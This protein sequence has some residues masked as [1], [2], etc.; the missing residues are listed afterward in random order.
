MLTIHRALLLLATLAF[1]LLLPATLPAQVGSTTDILTGRIT[2]PDSQP[3]AGAHVEAMSTE[4]GITRTTSTDARGRYTIVFPDGGGQYQ[5]TVRYLGMA[6]A[7]LTVQRQADEDRLITNVS[8]SNTVATLAP[9]TVRGRRQPPRQGRE[10]GGTGQSLPPGLVNRLPIDPGDLNALATLA[11]GVVGVAAT[12]STEA[13]FSVAGQPT[14]QNQITL[15]GLSFGSG[16]VPS[17]AIRSTRVITSTYDVARGQFTGGEVAATTRSGTNV[18]Q[19]AGTYSLRSRSLEL[20]ALPN[21]A[22]TQGFTQ[23]QFGAGAGGP[24]QKNKLFLFGA[25]QVNLRSDDVLSLLSASPATF[26]QLGANSDSVQRFLDIARGYGIPS[27]VAGAPMNR[28]TDNATALVRLD[29]NIGELHTLTLRGD[30]RGQSQ[31]GGRVSPLALPSTGGDLRSTGGG[32]M[33]ALT[34]RFGS[35]INE[36]RGYGSGNRRNADPYLAVPNARVVVQSALDDGTNAVSTLQLGGSP[37]L[38]QA[39]RTSLVE[40]SDEISWLS[41]NGGH[42]IKLGALYNRDQSTAETHPNAA[43][44]FTFNSLADLEAG[45]PTSF[46]RTLSSTDRSAQTENG[47]LYLGDMWRATPSLELS[48]GARLEGSR[49][50]GAP[51]Y[52]AAV[53]SAFGVRT[54]RFPSEVHLSPRVGFTYFVRSADGLPPTTLVRGGFGEFRGKA[55]SQLFAQAADANGLATGSTQIVCIGP[56]APVPDWGAYLADPSAIP[57][58]C[59]GPDSAVSRLPNVAVIAPGFQ[60]PRAWRGS[61]GVSHRFFRRYTLALDA[62]YARGVAQTG[63]IDLNLNATPQFTLANEGNRPVYVAAGAISP[64][65]GVLSQRDSRR[66]PDFGRVNE[67]TSTLHSETEQATLTFNTFAFGGLLLNASYTY[68]HARDQA[69]GFGANGFGAFGGTTAGNPNVAEWGRSDLERTHNFGLSLT[70]PLTTALEITAIGHLMSGPAYTPM[71]GSDVNGD[72]VANDRAFIF[73]PALAADTAVANG[74]ARL[75]ASAPARVRSCLQAQMGTIAARN[76]CAAPWQSSL[77]MQLNIKPS[78][79]GLDRRLT[80]SVQALNVLAGLDQLFHGADHLHGWGQP[81]FPDRTLLYVRGFDASTGT[82]QYSVNEHFGAATGTRSPFRIPF[83]LAIQARLTLGSD[84]ARQN[85][86][87][88][89]R[90]GRDG[91]PPTA[92]EL[93]ARMARAVPDPFARVI[94]INDSVGLALTDEQIVRL[95]ALSDSLHAAADP[96]LDSL[97]ATLAQAST[98]NPDPQYLAM[99]LR[100]RL[101]AA[102][103]LA[104]QA[105]KQAEHV[106]TPEQWAKV[107]QSIKMPFRPYQER[108]PGGGGMRRMPGNGAPPGDG[109]PT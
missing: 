95:H 24:L 29:Y 20:G 74:M 98:K 15:D 57:T 28:S 8:M 73:S 82:F 92:E 107:P 4:T 63:T 104:A 3:L 94:A 70:Y 43:G 100:P 97:A 56:F 6:P 83:Q 45:R 62:S 54:D 103:R 7:R 69:Y 86:R 52:N 14:N 5:L 85:M 108:G 106:L 31:D 66:D 78:T 19:S 46:T 30:W 75:L 2:G 11:P 53:D 10:P 37:S 26:Q 68:T 67:I 89:L 13:A 55:L 25:F 87:M 39:S 65:T 99:K 91:A 61:L 47:A 9:V 64:F 23:N 93:R 81:A 58:Q 88:V 16:S 71:V 77:D 44:T 18:F 34:S 42:R 49:H 90:G 36:L 32:G 12:D 84:P 17:E 38:P 21:S 96:L 109:P 51:A 59:A 101:E 105:I 50:P 33:L 1:P 102:R 22:F 76:S 35:F 27:V 40:I 72:G 80:V 48:L 60:A 79:L 41:P